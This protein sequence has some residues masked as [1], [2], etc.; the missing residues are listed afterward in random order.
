MPPKK[1]SATGAA[2][3]QPL[4]RTRRPFLF[5]RP[6]ARRGRPLVQHSRRRNWTKKSETWRLSTSK[7]K[8]RRRRWPDW[9]I[10][11]GRSMK[12]PKKYAILFK[13]NKIEGPNTGNFIKKACSTTMDGMMIL[14]MIPL[15]LMM[16]LRAPR[17]GGE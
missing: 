4:D 9:L 7:C 5:E 8:G 10:F 12:P 14:I 17:G 1:A 3:L 2:A 6:E 15:L 16:L 13:T 11:R